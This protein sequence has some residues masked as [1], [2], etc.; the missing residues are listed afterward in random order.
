MTPLDT[1]DVAITRRVVNA[2][3]RELPGLVV[4]DATVLLSHKGGEPQV[5]HIDSP[6]ALGER[7][8]FTRRSTAAGD[9]VPLSV[10]IGLQPG[11]TL[12]VW[13]GSHR[14]MHVTSER[15]FDGV[16]HRGVNVE[17]PATG[18]VVFR[19]DLVHAGDGFAQDNVRC[20]LFLDRK[21]S[22]PRG[23]AVTTEV[24]KLDMYVR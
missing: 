19:Q 22:E 3:G 14:D 18:F 17:V 24:A 16:V 1:N 15:A 8:A 13:P 7:R 21:G 12:W 9:V 2:V 6:Q 5:P 10:L 11:T 23:E 4:H 20:H